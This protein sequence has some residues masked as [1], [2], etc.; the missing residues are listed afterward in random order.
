[1]SLEKYLKTLEG[2]PTLTASNRATQI[3]QRLAN[4]L[5]ISTYTKL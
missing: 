5:E 4:L 3:P 1:M 2:R